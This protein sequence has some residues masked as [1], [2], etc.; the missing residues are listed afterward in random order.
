[1]KTVTF[2]LIALA[3]AF[4]ST[5]AAGDEDIYSG[6]PTSFA[7]FYEKFIKPLIEFLKFIISLYP[8]LPNG[9]RPAPSGK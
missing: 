1:M 7:G 5:V 9:S 2:V 8:K 4:A 6:P 3:I